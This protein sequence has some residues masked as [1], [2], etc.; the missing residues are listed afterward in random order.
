MTSSYLEIEGDSIL[1]SEH[2]WGDTL[3]LLIDVTSL[4]I[5]SLK[6]IA[7][8]NVTSELGLIYYSSN[9]DAMNA[10]DMFKSI[11]VSQSVFVIEAI[12]HFSSAISVSSTSNIT[13]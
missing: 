3:Q 6:L 13:Q 11:F 10:N 1:K 12:A 7:L 9:V 2:D 4:E 8:Q 5:S